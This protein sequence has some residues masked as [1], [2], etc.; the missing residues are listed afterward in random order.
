MA[1]AAGDEADVVHAVFS[2]LARHLAAMKLGSL[3]FGAQGSFCA[4]GLGLGLLIDKACSWDMLRGPPFGFPFR[5]GASKEREAA[6]GAAQ[7]GGGHRRPRAQQVLQLHPGWSHGSPRFELYESV[8]AERELGFCPK[9][10][11]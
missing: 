9:R 8:E 10:Y 5:W 2:T 3:G 6:C 7:G 11:P 4:G 1:D